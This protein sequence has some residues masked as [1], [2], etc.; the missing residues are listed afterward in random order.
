LIPKKGDGGRPTD[1]AYQMV[2]RYWHRRPFLV[3]KR[4][5]NTFK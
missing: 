4:Q 2:M 3:S 5:R 1:N